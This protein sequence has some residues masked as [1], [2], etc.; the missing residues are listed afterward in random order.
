MTDYQNNVEVMAHS[1]ALMLAPI[2]VLSEDDSLDTYN[3][4]PRVHAEIASKMRLE[5]LNDVEIDPEIVRSEGLETA[6]RLALFLEFDNHISDKCESY[7]RTIQKGD[8]K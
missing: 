1:L 8:A 4:A 5:Y 7:I 2:V 6:Y 3:M